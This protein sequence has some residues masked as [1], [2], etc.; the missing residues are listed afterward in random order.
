MQ[1]IYQLASQA[2]ALAEFSR[3]PGFMDALLDGR[4]HTDTEILARKEATVKL[5]LE[6]NEARNVFNENVLRRMLEYL[7]SGT[8]GSSAESRVAMDTS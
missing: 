7:G 1:V 8:G 2:W 5:I 4:V 6:Q 3:C